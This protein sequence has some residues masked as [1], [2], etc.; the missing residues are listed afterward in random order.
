M[1]VRTTESPKY[2]VE[3]MGR[4]EAS[5]EVAN[6]HDLVRAEEGLITPDK[7][8]R[9]IVRGI[10]DTGSTTLVLPQGLA[11]Q[12]GL[13]PKRKVNVEYADDHVNARDEVQGVYVTLLGRGGIYRAILEP[14][15]DTALISAIILEDLDLLVDCKRLRLVPRDPKH[16]V[17]DV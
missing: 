11:K 8:R 15:R 4:V 17:Y 2:G 10:V 13:T 5:L 12:L 7:I 16:K 6:Y 1:R 14:K 3:F 9:L